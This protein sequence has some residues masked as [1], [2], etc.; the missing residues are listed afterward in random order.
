MIASYGI[1]SRLCVLALAKS[2]GETLDWQI[3]AHCP[4]AFHDIFPKGI[5]GMEVKDVPSGPLVSYALQ[6]AT[7]LATGFRL[8]W[9]SLALPKAT[10]TALGIHFREHYP[11]SL[12]WETF[13]TKIPSS[14]ETA[15]GPVAVLADA[16]RK[17]ITSLLSGRSIPQLSR[18]MK[19]DLD[20]DT[21]S[22]PLY[23]QDLNQFLSSKT[24]L[25]NQPESC[26]IRLWHLYKLAFPQ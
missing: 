9:E 2:R 13:K 14:I 19:F 1:G 18:E 26:A 16:R 12:L 24:F 6:N 20:R 3:N 8:V 10:P 7:E 23:L 21:T 22:I 11:N 25:T 5:D 15:Q 4:N 17:E